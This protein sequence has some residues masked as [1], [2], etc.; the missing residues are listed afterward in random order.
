MD[1]QTRSYKNIVLYEI[2]EILHKRRCHKCWY[3]NIA[4]YHVA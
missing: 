3:V 2:L 1:T 4:T